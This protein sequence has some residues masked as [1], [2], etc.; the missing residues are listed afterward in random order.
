MKIEF[1]RRQINNPTPKSIVFKIAI[2]T[3]IIGYVGAYVQT[4]DWLGDRVQHIVGGSSL[5]LV[6]LLN[7][8]RPFFGVVDLPKTVDTHDIGSIEDKP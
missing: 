4:A 1:G 5:F 3:V 8:I 2:A 6:G 7:T